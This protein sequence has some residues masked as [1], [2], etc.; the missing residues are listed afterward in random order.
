MD[1]DI[2]MNL[3]VYSKLNLIMAR[4]R[5]TEE[6]FAENLRE[7]LA[8]AIRSIEWSYAIFWTISS[9]QPGYENI[10]FCF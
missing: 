8:L 1:L 5:Q 3:H 10:Y 9:A 7:K 4:G 6:G 2:I